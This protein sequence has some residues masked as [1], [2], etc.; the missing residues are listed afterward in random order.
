MSDIFA[1]CRERV[2]ASDAAELYAGMEIGRGECMCCFHDGNSKSLQFY[3]DGHFHCFGC[4]AHGSSIDF[5]K[6]WFNTDALGAVRRLNADFNLQL[7]LDR[8]QTEQDRAEAQRRDYVRRAQLAFESWRRDMVSQLC[9]CLRL[10]HGI[11]NGCCAKSTWADFTEAELLAL[12]SGANLEV[13]CETLEFGELD[14]QMQIFDRREE[15]EKTC[16]QILQN[17][18]N[19]QTG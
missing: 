13:I 8:P 10:Y 9:D 19:T 17:L 18:N 11:V 6:L 14:A 7:P 2:P 5:V 1:E 4:G 15:V 12:Q 16:R 3:P